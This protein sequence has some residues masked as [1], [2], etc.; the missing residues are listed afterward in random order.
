MRLRAFAPLRLIVNKIDMKNALS[1]LICKQDINMKKSFIGIS[2]VLLLILE[3]VNPIQTLSAQPVQIEK[4]TEISQ[5]GITWTFDKPALTGQFIT[6]DWWVIGP[7]RIVKVTPAPGPDSPDAK[8]DIKLDNWGSTS[9]NNDNRMRN[10]SMIILTA[11]DKQ[12]YDSRSISFD[13]ESCIALPVELAPDRSI[14][15]TIS[16]KTLPVDNFCAA[17]M[18]GKEV[19]EQTLLRTAAVLTCLSRV[20]PADAFRPPYAGTEKPIYRTGNIKWELLPNLQ[21]A[22]EVPSWEQYERYFQRPWL[23]HIPSWIQRGL[24]PNENQAAYGRERSRLVS[25]A[26]LMVLLDVPR[27]K[28]EKLSIELIQHGIDLSGVAKVGGNW[29]Q[30]GGHGS[31]RKWTILFAAL[32]LNDPGIAQLPESAIFHEDAQTYYGKGWFGQTVLW[33]MIIHHGKRDS[34]EE[35]PPEQ[36]EEWDR[37]SEGYRVCCNAVAW[38]G[39]ALAAR[40]MKAIKLWGHDAYFDYIDRWMRE[41]DP[42][43]EARG[44]HPRPG[45]ETQTID[46]FVTAMWKKY[47]ETAPVQEMSGNNMKFVWEGDKGVWIP[48]PR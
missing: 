27:E 30:G 43:K 21:P 32:M 33:Q 14:V 29:N 28:K 26:G 1:V 23:D 36:W 34:Y 20:P 18:W 42:Y 39:T 38:T 2:I 9:L 41:D 35:K 4:R 37:N 7:V 19:K 10:G 25:I 8:V 47:R 12:G 24:S 22:G 5:Y 11:S 15:S 48:N 45:G 31:G 13:P 46:P 16:H 3:G 44:T 6:G 17:I 40:Y